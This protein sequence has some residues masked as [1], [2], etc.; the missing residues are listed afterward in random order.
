M[1]ATLSMAICGSVL[2]LARRCLVD[3]GFGVGRR[4]IDRRLLHIGVEF[5][6]PRRGDRGRP[7]ADTDEGGIVVLETGLRHQIARHEMRAGAGRG[8]ADL[9][10]LEIGVIAIAARLGR[11]YAQDEAGKLSKLNHG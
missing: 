10:A 5:A 1:W 7:G 8:D 9:E 3:E 4:E 11:Q 2:M 6:T